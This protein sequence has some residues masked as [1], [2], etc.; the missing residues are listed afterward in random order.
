ML[1]YKNKFPYLLYLLYFLTY[2]YF[3]WAW[4]KGACSGN[5]GRGL[6]IYA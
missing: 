4:P 3:L 1:I 6:V 2:L 5:Y